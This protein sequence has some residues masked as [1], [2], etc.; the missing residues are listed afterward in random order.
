MISDHSNP[1]RPASPRAKLTWATSDLSRLLDPCRQS[2]G[3]KFDRHL[4]LVIRLPLG[5]VRVHDGPRLHIHHADTDAEYGQELSEG[6]HHPVRVQELPELDRAFLRSA[7]GLLKRLLG[8]DLL[9]PLTLDNREPSASD[10]LPA[11]PVRHDRGISLGKVLG[12][13]V[14]NRNHYRTRRTPGTRRGRFADGDRGRHHGR[15]LHGFACECRSNA[16]S[17][18]EAQIENEVRCAPGVRD[19][20]Y[21]PI[22]IAAI[23]SL[24]KRS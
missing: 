3:K 9:H 1:I 20:G 13:Q 21:P 7:S 8:K 23:R 12:I 16:E 11:Q 22:G 15:G 17:N 5:L 2:L 19:A 10:Q 14:G 4:H 24:K 18:P 6:H